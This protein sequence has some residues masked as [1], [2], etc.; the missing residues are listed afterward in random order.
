MERHFE[1]DLNELK[2]RLLWM[3]SLA[4]RAVHQ[5]VHAVLDSD[6]QLAKRVLDEED[7]INELQMEID[8]RVV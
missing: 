3:G 7:A 5:A 2:E 8:D 6:E 4:E 1:R